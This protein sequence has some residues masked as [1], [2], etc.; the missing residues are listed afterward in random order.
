MINH[1]IISKLRKEQGAYSL[2]LMND[3]RAPTEPTPGQYHWLTK[4]WQSAHEMMDNIFL[5]YMVAAYQ[6]SCW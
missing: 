1:L 2:S 4:V 6:K 3:A 5:L